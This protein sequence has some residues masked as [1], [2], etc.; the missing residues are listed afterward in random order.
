MHASPT[1]PPAPGRRIKRL[2]GE[3][4][5]GNREALG[6][7]LQ[8]F[9]LLLLAEANAKLPPGLEAKA[10]GSDL[11][12]E[13]FL[14]AQRD[15]PQF[16]GTTEAELRAWLL[17]ILDH[18]VANLRRK[19]YDTAKSQVCR[20]A[21]L[22]AGST[23]EGPGDWLT[24]GAPSPSSLAVSREEEELLLRAL[25]RLTDEERTVIRLRHRE[26]ATFT[27]IADRMG[28]PSAEAARKRFSRAVEELS[29][30]VQAA[31]QEQSGQAPGTGAPHE[32]RG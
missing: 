28:L 21:P 12:Q 1:P 25:G 14:E 7:L 17:T 3:A 30:H 18:N 2:I 19:Y 15:F 11:V 20:E 32:P 27:E 9:R 8:A 4:R 16:I 6:E 22:D 26:E 24:T 13:T 29:R 10:G 31:Q 23:S 5:G